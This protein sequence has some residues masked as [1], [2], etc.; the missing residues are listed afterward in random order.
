MR[1]LKNFLRDESK[2]IDISPLI[3]MVFILLVFF[4]VA[5]SFIE[6]RGLEPKTNDGPAPIIDMEE[7]IIVR[8]RDS[9]ELVFAERSV[10]LETL[11][12]MLRSASQMTSGGLIVE[13]ESEV[14]T[15]QLV[16]VMDKVVAAGIDSSVLKQI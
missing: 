9:G 15:S 10:S 14:N 4:V 8:I 1:K 13:L 12:T 6:E 5:T 3:D 2:S 7:P 16:A 11:E